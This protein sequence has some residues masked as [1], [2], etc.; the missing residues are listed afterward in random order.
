MKGKISVIIPV[1]NA[2]KTLQRCLDSIAAQTYQNFEVL[3]VDDGSNDASLSICQAYSD[4]DTRFKVF[5]KKNG[6]VSSARNLALKNVTG[7]GV[8]FCDSDDRA[9]P[10][11]L[12]NFMSLMNADTDIV[13]STY[14]EV[15][16]YGNIK[17]TYYYPFNT[18]SVAMAWLLMDI[19]TG[20]GY[21]T[22]KCFKTDII[23]RQKLCFNESY[24]FCEDEHFVAQYMTYVHNIAI[25]KVP[26]YNY[27]TSDDISVWHKKY[28][29][30]DNFNCMVEIYH[31]MT[32]FEGANE[33][34]ERFYSHI[35]DRVL[36][37]LIWTYMHN[38]NQA[39]G[40]LLKVCNI[41][42]N[43]RYIPLN[44]NRVSRLLFV[45]HPHISHS[46]FKL[47]AAIHQL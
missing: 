17:K 36:E 39:F 3:I 18:S 2:E 34:P 5:Y 13:I 45:H 41:L 1:Y 8:T 31:C 20:T 15:S 21:V 4:K 11:W 27:I 7:G 46:I 44:I 28:D 33:M 23:K 10:D 35:V 25:C 24:S 37:G 40:H 30:C 38:P 16:Q 14:R 29:K 6:G 19:T 32:R 42:N 26:A 22:S 47:L 9:E 43:R 12:A